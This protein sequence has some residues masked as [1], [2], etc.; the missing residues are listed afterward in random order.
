M[1]Y[2]NHTLNELVVN[3]DK[4][5]K[6][7]KKD[8]EYI[9]VI[10]CEEASILAD[11]IRDYQEMRALQ[12]Y[13]NELDVAL[14]DYIYGHDSAVQFVTIDQVDMLADFYIRHR[15]KGKFNVSE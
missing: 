9:A 15:L 7:T 1:T 2:D 8:E 5:A 11:V 12:E 13:R 3:L 4:W 14:K 10:T 6:H